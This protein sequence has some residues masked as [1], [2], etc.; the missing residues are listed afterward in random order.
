MTSGLLPRIRTRAVEAA[1][2]LPFLLAEVGASFVSFLLFFLILFLAIAITVG[3]LAL[4]W[5]IDLLGRWADVNRRRIGARTGQSIVSARQPREGS[6]L[7]RAQAMLHD[8]AVRRELTWVAGHG[9]P[10]LLITLLVVALPLGA[11]NAL[12][13]PGYWWVLPTDQPAATVF[14]V[15]SWPLAWATFVIGLGYAALALWLLPPTARLRVW[16]TVR[17]LGLDRAAHL[18]EQVSVLTASRASALEAHRAELRRIERDLHDGTQNKLVGVVMH[19]GILERSLGRE[20]DQ[21]RPLLEKAQAAAGTALAE[22]RDVVRSIYPPVLDEHGLDGAV[23]HAV[24]RCPVPCTLDTEGLR[25]APTAIESAAYFVISEA[26]TNVARHSHADRAS[27][28]VRTEGSAADE[29]LVV[30]VRDNGVG[31]AGRT[32]GGTGIIG[33]RRRV[34]AFSGLV[35]VSSPDGGPT[36]LRVELPCGS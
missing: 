17:F 30:E 5:A 1:R 26:L 19:L 21:V 33:I 4:P 16:W 6:Y 25:R 36:L 3:W 8:R 10:G 34:E 12:L 20:P 7:E 32:A 9:L 13:I 22:L 31:G 14:D 18:S 35:E 28:T 11:A 2:V 29:R 15:T 23:A 27:V 24:A